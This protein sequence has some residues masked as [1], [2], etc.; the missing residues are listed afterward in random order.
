MSMNQNLIRAVLI[1]VVG[2]A[3]ISDAS[4]QG[5]FIMGDETVETCGGT[6]MDA[7]NDPTNGTGNPYPDENYTYTI[8]P[9]NPD[10]AVSVSFV[11]FGLQ[12][13][14]N[15]NNSDY[16][17]IFDGPDAGSP[18]MGNYTGNTLQ[19]LPVTATI[20][21]PTGCLTFVFQDNGP[22]NE[23]AP[24]WEAEITCTTPCATPTAASSI[25]DPPLPNPDSLSIGVCLEAEVTFGDAGSIAEPGFSLENWIW[26]FDDGTI[27]TLTSASNV[28]HSFD[29]PGEYIVNLSVVDDNGC[30]SLNLQPLQVLVGTFLCSTA[31]KARR[32]VP[33]V[34]LCGRQSRTKCDVDCPATSGRGRRDLP[35]RWR[36]IQLH[37]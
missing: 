31:S 23:L 35:R 7:G 8:C 6:F 18:S 21:N 17:F 32:C 2:M 20:N 36:G 5:F 25:V 1:L 24:G 29:E 37:E 3:S 10:D 11:A 9:D 30:V 22:A 28:V 4:A 14:P 19:G 27:D 13:N 34:R 12:T 33:A 16:L 26:N 15:P